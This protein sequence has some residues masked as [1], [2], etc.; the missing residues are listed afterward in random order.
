MFMTKKQLQRRKWYLTHIE[1]QKESSR[2][3]YA[4]NK[5]KARE[6]NR[7]WMKQNPYQRFLKEERKRALKSG[8]T[9]EQLRE[10]LKN[11]LV[12]QICKGS[13]GIRGPQ[14]DHCHKTNEF[15]G[16]LCANCNRGLGYFKDQTSNLKAAIDY[17]D[18]S[19][20]LFV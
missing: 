12:C 10:E 13:F 9:V 17:L 2:R 18:S 4:A 1:Q 7:R 14:V 16:I 20:S 19:V 8:L 6:N 15:R 3:W 5:D 11:N